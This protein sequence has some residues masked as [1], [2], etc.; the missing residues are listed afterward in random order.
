M[1]TVSRLGL[2]NPVDKSC[3][4]APEHR[5]KNTIFNNFALSLYKYYAYDSLALQHGIDNPQHPFGRLWNIM[6]MRWDFT[7]MSDF[8]IITDV[9]LFP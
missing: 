7:K 6:S 9:F 8:T 5:A 2:L 3:Q 4:R 1:K